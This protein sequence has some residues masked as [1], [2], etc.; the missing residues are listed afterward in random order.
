MEQMKD[1]KFQEEIQ[2]MEY[3]PLSNV[4]KR[5]CA[6][7][8]GLGVVLLVVLYFVSSFIPGAHGV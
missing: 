2:K 4:E 5:L 6:W 8:F 1:L 7:G 3:E